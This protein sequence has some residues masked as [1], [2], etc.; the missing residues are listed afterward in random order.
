MVLA[1]GRGKFVCGISVKICRGFG[2]DGC[3]SCHPIQY[4]PVLNVFWRLKA[5]LIFSSCGVIFS[6]R[7][8]K[9]DRCIVVSIG[10]IFEYFCP[11]FLSSLQTNQQQLS[12]DAVSTHLFR[13]F[14]NFPYSVALRRFFWPFEL[15]RGSV[16]LGP[17]SGQSQ[18]LHIT[19]S[20]VLLAPARRG[21]SGH[22]QHSN[23]NHVGQ[24]VRRVVTRCYI[25]DRG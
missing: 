17:P 12:F 24:D 11:N 3:C 23:K 10:R 7:F 8:A 19:I 15:R 5:I 14:P 4:V 20:P 22:E 1:L 2:K 9:R 25:A 6:S 13:F 21:S 16:V 18:E